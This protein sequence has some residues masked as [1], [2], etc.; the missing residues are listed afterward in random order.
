MMVDVMETSF[1]FRESAA[2]NIEKLSTEIEKSSTYGVKFSNETKGLI[3]TENVAYAAHKTWGSEIAEA[4][5]KIKA[6]Y[7]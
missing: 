1:Y 4:Q 6:K 5:R 7:L 3:V 2:T